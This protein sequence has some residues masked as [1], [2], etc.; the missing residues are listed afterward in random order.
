MGNPQHLEWLL[1]G[2]E[3]WNARRRREDF[4]PDFEGTDIR[5]AF[6]QAE[7]LPETGRIP[8]RAANLRLGDL[9]ETNL[10]DADLF[11]ANLEGAGLVHANLAGSILGGAR[12]E[13]AEL[14]GADLRNADLRG[15]N[16]DKADLRRVDLRSAN[17]GG[18]TLVGADLRRSNLY[19]TDLGWADL[20]GADI[21]TQYRS[22]GASG[23]ITPEYTDLS[24]ATGLTQQQL[25]TMRGDTGVILPGRLRHPSDWPSPAQTE[26]DFGNDQSPLLP[27]QKNPQEIAIADGQLRLV[28]LAPPGRDDLESIHSDLREDVAGLRASGS[29]DNISKG[30]GAV[31]ARFARIV[32]RDYDTLDQT[33]LGVQTGALRKRLDGEREEIGRIDPARLGELDAVLM[34]AELLAARLPEWQAFLAETRADRDAVAAETDAVDDALEQASEAMEADPTHFDASL[35]DRLREYWDT[36]TTEAYLAGVAMLNDAAFVVFKAVKQFARDT[37]TESRKVAVKGVASALVAGLGSVLAK[38]AGIVP[39]ELEWVLPWLKYVPR[40]FG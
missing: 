9:R 24:F 5:E 12:L 40:L 27:D 21:R 1:E 23:A 37:G 32:D 8:L 39:A 35:P 14:W 34:A 28:D 13:N 36:K 38:L 6:D 25:G 29:L 11:N 10:R 18:A 16:L 15:A 31:F 4:E 22:A 33:R 3:A 30:L 2:V 20:R 19:R 26:I 7:Q 17:L